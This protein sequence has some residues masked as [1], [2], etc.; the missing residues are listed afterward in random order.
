M[1][2]PQRPEQALVVRAWLERRELNGLEPVFRALLTVVET[3]ERRWAS[4]LESLHAHVDRALAEAG[5]VVP[6]DEGD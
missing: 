5:V 4:S 2:H 6:S 1:S 3:G